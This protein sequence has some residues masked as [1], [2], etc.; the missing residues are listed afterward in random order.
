MPSAPWKGVS[1]QCGSGYW[2][3]LGSSYWSHIELTSNQTERD[4]RLPAGLGRSK[5]IY[6][7]VSHDE[8]GS[9]ESAARQ[10]LVRRRDPA[11]ALAETCGVGIVR[12][13]IS[14]GKLVSDQVSGVEINIFHGCGSGSF[15]PLE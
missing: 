15:T 7:L 1:S 10:S 14:A 8:A 11:A 9:D 13:H 6:G 5:G 12:R 2:S 4:C 3:S